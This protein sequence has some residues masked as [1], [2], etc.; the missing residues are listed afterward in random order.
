MA[1]AR[2]LFRNTASR[3]GFHSI[4][5]ERNSLLRLLRYDRLILHGRQR[6]YTLST[7]TREY[8]LFCA[9]G[10]AEVRVADHMFFMSPLDG[11]Y[12]PPGLDAR[13]SAPIRVDLVIGSTPGDGRQFPPAHVPITEIRGNSACHLEAGDASSGDRRDVF[14]VLGDQ[15][16]AARLYMGYT[17]GRPGQWTSWPPHEHAAQM[18]EI[19]VFF[20]M[21]PPGWALQCLFSKNPSTPGA[22]QWV[23]QGDAVAA[24][25]GYHPNAGFPGTEI[26]YIWMMAARKKGGRTWVQ[27]NLHADYTMSRAR[28]RGR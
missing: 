17:R 9:D 15:I 6:S 12:L 18:E 8:G 21:R 14:K 20:D 11:L 27:P 1:Q 13:V 28:S 7:G 22:I 2:W 23:R 16:Q 5:N 26:C 19:Y 3:L 10:G 4:I 25:G 24:D